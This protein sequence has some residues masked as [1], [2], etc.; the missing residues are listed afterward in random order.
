MYM[1]GQL[2]HFV[3]IKIA[4]IYGGLFATITHQGL[5]KCIPIEGPGPCPLHYLHVV[6]VPV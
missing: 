5:N 1:Y 3:C 6:Y 4:I 2:A